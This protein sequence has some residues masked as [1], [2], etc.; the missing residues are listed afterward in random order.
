MCLFV[1]WLVSWMDDA[2]ASGDGEIGA[3]VSV[4]EDGAVGYGDS[5]EGVSGDC[6]SGGG[7]PEGGVKVGGSASS[8]SR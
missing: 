6:V 3:C 1:G 4:R 5:A 2:V 8:A 7:D